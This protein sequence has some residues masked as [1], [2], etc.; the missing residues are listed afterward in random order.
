[1]IQYKHIDASIIDA[2]RSI[3]GKN[4]LLAADDEKEP[5]SH[6]ETLGQKFMP[7]AVVR[8]GD[9]SQVAA[10]M[11]LAS[12]GKIPVTPRGAGTG[13]SGG[14]LPVCGGIVLSLE[15]LNKILEIDEENLMAVVQ[16][17]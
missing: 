1:M 3:V 14:A 16:L 17:A 4:Q 15:R 5:Y 6:D 13:L 9:A 7:A 11:K 10:I 12:T 2:I 8:P